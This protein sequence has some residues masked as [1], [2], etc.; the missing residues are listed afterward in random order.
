MRKCAL[1]SLFAL[2]FGAFAY[3]GTAPCEGGAGSASIFNIPCYFYGGDLLRRPYF[4]HEKICFQSFFML[5]TVQPFD[6]ASS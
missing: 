6:F 2:L 5:I 1:L 3:G 4:S